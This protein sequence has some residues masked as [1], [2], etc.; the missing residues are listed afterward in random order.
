VRWPGVTTPIDLNARLFRAP[1]G[2]IVQAGQ[3]INESG[4][5]L[6]HSNA[7]LVLLRPGTRGTDAPVLGPIVSL[8]RTVQVG[9]DLTLTVG[10][11]DNAPLQTHQASVVWTDGC[12]SPAPTIREAGGSGQV[13]LR[14]R[15]CAAG[16]QAV[17]I[18]VTDSGGRSTELVQ[19]VV[20]EDPAQATLTGAG[21]LRGG[22]APAGRVASNVPLRFSL[23]S[24]LGGSQTIVAAK[25]VVLLAGPFNF[26]S[27]QVASAT[28]DGL[29]ARV[30]G[31]GRFNGRSGYRFT[32]EARDGAQQGQ[33][34]LRVRITHTD[35][36]G[37][38]VVDYDNAAPANLRAAAD[39]A[40][41]DHSVVADGGLTVRN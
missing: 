37:A 38:D 7:G 40:A 13:T 17:R 39:T 18:K 33:D 23:W 32:V 5:I 31:T 9:Q 27:E 25:P 36:A 6:A 24:P 20:V 28:R 26:R 3:A 35:A 11:V 21:T 10:F 14:H 4:A 29:Q 30:T 34:R 22:T 41:L 8:P 1:A 15:F 2:L 16:F 19:D 12:T